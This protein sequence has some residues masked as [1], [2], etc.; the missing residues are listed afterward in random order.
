MEL[1]P[2]SLSGAIAEILIL[3]FIAASTGWLC[4]RAIINKQ[5]YKINLEVTQ[6]KSE[7]AHYK[8]THN[9]HAFEPTIAKVS[10]TV[11]PDTVKT[12]AEPDNFLLIEGIGPKTVE[13]L[14]KEGILTFEQLAGT[15]AI[16]LSGILKKAGPR[17]QIQDPTYWPQQASF[18]KDGQWEQ[19][20]EYQTYLTA[21]KSN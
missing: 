20:K 9:N 1:N 13:L 10:K 11:Y 18:A 8:I 6:K 14:N 7:L 5:L 15:S 12:I 19:L 21:G 3:L 16:M 4:A 17:F 2:Q